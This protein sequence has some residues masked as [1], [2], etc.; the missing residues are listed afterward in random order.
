MFDILYAGLLYPVSDWLTRTP[1]HH[2]VRD[3]MRA[4]PWI[5]PAVQTLHIVSIGVVVGSIGM[6]NLRLLGLAGRRQG[7]DEMGRRLMPWFWSA[8]ALLA[9]TGAVLVM[10]RPARYF[11]N[12]VFIGKLVLLL[13]VLGLTLALRRTLATGAAPGHG[14]VRILAGV[15]VAL[16]IGV[17]FA[18]RWI[19]Y[20]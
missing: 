2:A 5:N 20:V 19:A 1:A 9:M 15:S 10:T 4:A 11:D 14:A 12:P 16:W 6:I 18:G 17:I 3:L 7:L 13:A 8:L